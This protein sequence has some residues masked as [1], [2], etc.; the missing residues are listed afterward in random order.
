MTDAEAD[1]L[2]NADAYDLAVE[3]SEGAEVYKRELA[4]TL[5]IHEAADRGRILAITEMYV[6]M[7]MRDGPGSSAPPASIPYAVRVVIRKAIEH[8]INEGGSYGD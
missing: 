8:L 4:V 3:A 1:A 6:L 2:T 7:C 5:A